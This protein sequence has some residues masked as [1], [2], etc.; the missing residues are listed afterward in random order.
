M[1]TPAAAL[2]LPGVHAVLWHGNAPRLHEVSDGELKVFQSDRVAYRGQIVAAVIA[3]SYET[4]RQAERLV[5]IEYAPGAPRRAAAR[6]PPGAV[7]ARR[8]SIRTIPR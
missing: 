4:A 2:A 6:R 7:H 5:R 1:S 3:D 8:R